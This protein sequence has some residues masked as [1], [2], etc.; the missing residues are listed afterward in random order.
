MGFKRQSQFSVSSL[1]H[2]SSHNHTDLFPL[3]IEQNPPN[4]PQQDSP[5]PHMPRE[6]TPQQ[7]TPGPSGT[8]WLE[9]LSREPSQTQEPPI[10]GPSPSS[11]PPEDVPTCEQKSEVAPTQST[12]EPLCKKLIHFLTLPNFSSPFLQP[13]PACPATPSSVI[14]INNTPVGSRPSPPPT[15]PPSPPVPPPFAAENPTASSH[16]YNDA[17]QEFTNLRPKLMIP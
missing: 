8:C 3:L 4:P 7:P 10:P 11:E 17:R 9:D 13:S 12:E 6:Q 1:T 14:V 16:S 2:F 5:V 15:L